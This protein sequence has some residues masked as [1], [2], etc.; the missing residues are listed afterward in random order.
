MPVFS[1]FFFFCLFVF[2]VMLYYRD[3]LKN[4]AFAPP[5]HAYMTSYY[6]SSFIWSVSTKLNLVQSFE[7]A[8]WTLFYML[9]FLCSAILKRL[10]I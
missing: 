7:A 1:I 4:A 3:I 5:H 10:I 9:L 2:F 6:I 8:L